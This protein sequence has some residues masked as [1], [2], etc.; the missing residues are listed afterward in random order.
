MKKTNPEDMANFLQSAE[1]AKM[2]AR[3]GHKVIEREYGINTKV[4]MF[5]KDA[6]RGRYLEIPG[7]P[8]IDWSDKKTV[9]KVFDDIKKIAKDEGCVFVRLRP[10]LFDT[11]ENREILKAEGCRIAPMHLAA[12]HT[13]IIDLDKDEETLL[14]NMR[15]EERRVG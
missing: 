9:T 6:K 4:Y 14:A 11:P 2:N 10:Q 8:L 15:S 7:G 1:W 13:V 12:E 3:I 5:V